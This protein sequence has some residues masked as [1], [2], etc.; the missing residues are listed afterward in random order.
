MLAKCREMF[1]TRQIVLFGFS[2]GA[3]MIYEIACVNPDLFDV[4]MG[5]GI[6]PHIPAT[7]SQMC[8]MTARQVMMLHHKV[9]HFFHWTADEFCG[10]QLFPDWHEE[11]LKTLNKDSY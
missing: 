6:Y 4:G 9:L 10:Y 1:P 8:K 2:R 11:L 3:R 7:D 5:I